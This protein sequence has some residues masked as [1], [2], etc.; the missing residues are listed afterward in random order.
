MKHNYLVYFLLLFVLLFRTN[1]LNIVNNLTSNLF[2]KSNNLEVKL[3]QSENKYLLKEYDDLLNF[4][5]N[6]DINTDYTIT[7]VLKNSYGFDSLIIN[8][9]YKIGDE[10][11]SENGLI[12]VI[13]NSYNNLSNVRYIYKTDLIIKI[14]D[15][16]GKISSK[17]DE[18]NL[19]VTEITNYNNIKLNDLVYSINDTL[20]GKVIKIKY[21]ILDNYLT[22]KTVPLDNLNYVAVISR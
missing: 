3:L 9:S 22:V 4:K 5:T 2:I 7:N 1:I 17:D 20:I 18:N 12:G 13:S 15:E 6:I 21:D 10:V 19:I 8:G 11:I 16:I 14:N